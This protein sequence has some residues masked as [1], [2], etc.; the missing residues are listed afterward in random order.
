MCIYVIYIDSI[1]PFV[2][3]FCPQYQNWLVEAWEECFPH[4]QLRVFVSVFCCDK[5]IIWESVSVF[6]EK[7]IFLGKQGGLKDYVGSE[8]IDFHN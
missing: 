8:E 5:W 3:V 1:L 7:A 6:E 4:T 2:F